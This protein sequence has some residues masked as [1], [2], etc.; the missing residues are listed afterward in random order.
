MQKGAL[1]SKLS[2]EMDNALNNAVG[3]GPHASRCRELRA[4]LLHAG[5]R[6]AGGRDVKALAGRCQRGTRP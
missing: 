5:Q 2:S 6:A 4:C 3:I 1:K